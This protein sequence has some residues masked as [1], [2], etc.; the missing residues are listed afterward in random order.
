MSRASWSAA[1]LALA[2]LLAGCATGP[3]HPGVPV[4]DTL[5]GAEAAQQARA[6]RL[7]EI[8]DWGFQGRLAVSTGDRGGSGRL[9]WSQRGE[10]YVAALSAPVTRQSWRLRGG[11]EGAVLEGLEGG[12]RRGGDADALLRE[13]TGWPIPVR[14]LADWV[15]GL[16]TPGARVGYGADGR[17]QRI[18]VDGWTIE[19]QA[20]WPASGRLP[21]MPARVQATRADARVR[22]VVDAWEVEGE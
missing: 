6:R 19:Y 22:L 12:P 17:L 3:G 20:W 11:P 15:R 2:L 5:A 1:G 16:A 21:E 4:A 8:T 9:D 10:G 18:E 13:A 14:A 7:A